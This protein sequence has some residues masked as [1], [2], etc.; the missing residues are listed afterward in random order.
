ML[1]DHCG[2]AWQF[3]LASFLLFFI[4][5]PAARG[6]PL[7][8]L[9]PIL[10]T[11][12]KPQPPTSYSI[13]GFVYDDSADQGT[14][15]L[16]DAGLPAVVMT[17]LQNS[18]TGTQTFT[19][20][21]NSAG[22]YTFGGLT[23]GDSYEILETQPANFTATAETVGYFQNS[24]GGILTAPPGASNGTLAPPNAISGIEFA[25]TSTGVYSAVNY[26]F[27]ESP[28]DFPVYGVPS[29]PIIP[30]G[31]APGHND[32]GGDSAA[33]P[34]PST[35]ALLAAGVAGLLVYRVRRTGRRKSLKAPTV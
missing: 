2:G 16:D 17:L 13:S 11:P 10:V 1:R 5:S 32:S 29:M 28:N 18:S 8:G 12:S 24:T 34:E 19:G 27:G 26:N 21:T 35:F 33:A 14:K 22:Y 20:Y 23:A 9:P 6:G 31:S 30:G 15:L 7:I 4:Y 25:P 3:L